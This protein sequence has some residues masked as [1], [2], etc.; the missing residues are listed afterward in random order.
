[1]KESQHIIKTKLRVNEKV[2][3]KDEREA[4][5]FLWALTS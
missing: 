5:N 3:A 4:E 2:R 1:M